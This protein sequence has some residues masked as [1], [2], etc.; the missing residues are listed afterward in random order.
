ML[1]RSMY[2]LQRDCASE[3]SELPHVRGSTSHAECAA[4]ERATRRQVAV[5]C[6]RHRESAKHFVVCC[7]FRQPAY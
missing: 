7:V 2:K 3:R 1:G 4:G 5:H 6:L